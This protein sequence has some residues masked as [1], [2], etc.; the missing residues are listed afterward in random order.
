MSLS[1]KTRITLMTLAI[2]M[3][4]LWVLSYYASRMLQ[5]DMERLLSEQQAATTTYAASELQGKLEERIKA[6]ELIASAIDGPLLNN[7]PDLQKFLDQRFVLH[8][9]FN[10]GV[11]GY[12]IDGTSIVA[13]P[14]A[15]E[16]VGGN[17]LDRDYLLGAIQNG[18]STIGQPV[19][20]RTAR[21][22]VVIMAVPIRDKQGKV[23]GAFSGVTNLNNPN[24]LDN[25]TS[26]R[27]GRTGGYFIMAPQH[28]LIVAATDKSRA[29]EALP[30]PGVNPLL[31]RRAQ[32]YEGSEIFVNTKGV[33]V[34][35]SAKGVP[36]AGWYVSAAL[37]VAEAFAPIQAMKQRMWLAT[38][39]LTLLAGALTWWV[40]RRQLLP[41]LE[42]AKTLTELAESDQPPRPL[43]ITRHDE[44]GQVIGGFNR[45]LESLEKRDLALSE[46]ESQYRQLYDEVPVG[47]HEYD[48]HGRITRINQTELV[49]LGY[50][51]D[52]MLG[53]YVWECVADSEQSRIRTLGK[54]AG[55]YPLNNNTERYA[56]RKDGTA[57]PGLYQDKPCFDAAGRITGI[58]TIMLPIAERKRA[59]EAL[60]LSE[61][62]YRAIFETSQ[63]GISIIRMSDGLHIEA[64]PSFFDI[65]G[66]SRDEVIGRTSHELNIWANPADR[67]RFIEQLQRDGRCSNIEAQFRR[68]D[69][70]LIWGLVSSS[71]IDIEGTP[72]IITVRRD[73]T[74]RKQLEHSL[75][76][77]ENQLRATLET[78]PSVAV[79][80]YD[81]DAR[82][83]YWNPASTILFG[84]SADE[85]I[86]KTLDQMIY[87]VEEAA[88][89]RKL[90]EQIKSSGK[91]FGPYEAMIQRRDKSVGWI[92]SSTYAISAEQDKTI[93]VCMDVDITTRKLAEE[94]INYLAFFD[95]LTG[96]PNRTLLQDRLKQTMA[97]SQRSSRYGAL[98]LLNLDHFKTLNDTLGHDMGDLLLKQ[99]AQRLTG[100]V[101]KED[102]VARFGGDEFVVMLVNLS[103]SLGEAASLV[104]LIGE[105]ISA[106][107]NLPFDLKEIPYRISP[108]LGASLFLGQQSDLDVLLKQADLAMYKAKEA[109][110]NTLRFFDPDMA[111]NALKRAVLD[112]D[113]R[114]AI[115]KQQFLLHYQAQISGNRVIGAEALLRW[116]HPERGLVSP[117]AFITALEETGLILPVGQWVLETASQQLAVWARIPEMSHLTIAVN[118]SAR[119]LNHENFVDQVLR[120]LDLSGANP[121]RLK[122]ELTESL[123]VS[124]VEEI[125]DKMTTLKAKGVGFSLDDFGTGYSSLAYL[126][127]LPLD[128]LKI[129]QGFVRDI[130]T[131]P[132]DAAIAR[133]IVV[134]AET[135]GLAVIAE[136]VE[137]EAQRDVLTQQGCHAYQGY[138]FG[139]PLPFDEFE[140]VV[141]RG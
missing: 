86:G 97:S 55:T 61:K 117:A 47:Y 3:A 82:V 129:D 9:L 107:F 29:M 8:S 15:P 67:Q 98:L 132:N 28:R 116:Q 45:L 90:L 34:L 81:E 119:Q 12:Q 136:G 126:K 7:P 127:R 37:P 16:R 23:I 6:L 106:A 65:Q 42:T 10:D 11:R 125:I 44:I 26:S 60:K 114:E 140:S 99:V 31:D 49:M 131:D 77:R 64:N 17:Y 2:F 54:L 58:R 46:S 128:Q 30:L 25:I 4:S 92:L 130:L 72:C 101:R 74:E 24:F 96:L 85:A 62:R 27:Y 80:W 66:Y 38:L 51:A 13:S 57:L 118:I 68:K 73:I 94:K 109:G 76:I 78:N 83:I 40:L 18:K 133:M 32:G 100:C 79:Q 108:S 69:G 63:D 95:Q 139:R 53:H 134:L 52:E 70:E 110:R 75:A 43:P 91:P 71:V 41:L 137:T 1:L 84:W 5:T 33:G 87:T 135:L 102:T 112:N 111:H 105:K 138:L 21:A 88:E 123:L 121:Q 56:L 22:A 120:A 104:D 14:P 103:G 115:Q 124:N 19:I 59:E 39:F 113:L 48:M 141:K 20:G 89:F 122:L 35:S 36:V 50:S 93:F